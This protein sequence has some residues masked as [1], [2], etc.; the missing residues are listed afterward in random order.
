MVTATA[1]KNTALV[2][3]HNATP[4]VYAMNDVAQNMSFSEI[5]GMGN[6]LVKTGFLPRNITNGVQFAA[7]VLAGREMGIPTMR[8]VRTLKLVMGNVVEDASA[9]LARFKADGGRA[10]FR[11]LDAQRAELW[12]RHPNGDEHVETFSLED[13][14][15]AGLT[16]KGEG[17]Q[18]F[19]A[20]M[21]RSRAITA[22]LKSV[23]WNGAPGVYGEGELDD[24]GMAPQSSVVEAP[25]QHAKPRVHEVIAKKPAPVEV[26]PPVV[27]D[28]P[29]EVVNEV[30]GEVTTQLSD[31]ERASGF[32]EAFKRFKTVA[33]FDDVAGSIKSS[34]WQDAKGAAMQRVRAAWMAGRAAIKG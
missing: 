23:G 2:R 26:A 33:E 6:A 16:G 34:P 30:T 18:R 10:T 7:I 28:A 32:I 12:L 13:A 19:P 11:H 31:D 9:Q 24:V 8:A 21:L 4:D 22:G 5:E 14:K 27:E 3:T 15:R 29:S 20:A 25:Q 17:W 1:E